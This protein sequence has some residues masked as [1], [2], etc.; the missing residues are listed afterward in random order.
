[1]AKSRAFIVCVGRGLEAPGWQ[2]SEMDTALRQSGKDRDLKIIP[3]L[4]PG[5][6]P[7]RLSLFLKTRQWLDLR[8]TKI[9]DDTLRPLARALQYKT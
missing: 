9:T 7:E 4:L 6:G 5:A 8:D 2:A 3:I 1:M